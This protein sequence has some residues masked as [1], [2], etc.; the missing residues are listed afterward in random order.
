MKVPNGTA[1]AQWVCDDC[2]F[3]EFCDV[4]GW[5]ERQAVAS[6]H[7]T[8]RKGATRSD[9]EDEGV[10]QPQLTTAAANERIIL[11]GSAVS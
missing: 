11:I 9:S 3:N 5:K 10:G 6:M 1:P 8:E 2:G 4:A 7:L